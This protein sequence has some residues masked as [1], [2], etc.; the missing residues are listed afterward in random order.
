VGERVVELVVELVGELVV[1][2]V[3]DI[4]EELPDP[5]PAE[6]VAIVDEVVIA[7]VELDELAVVKLVLEGVG[8]VLRVVFVE[9]VEVGGSALPPS[10][11]NPSVS[12]CDWNCLL[13]QLC[14]SVWFS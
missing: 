13:T 14:T 5:D 4:V 9:L 3:V 8:V 7:V 6:V 12:S 10:M 2:L 1:E 11:P